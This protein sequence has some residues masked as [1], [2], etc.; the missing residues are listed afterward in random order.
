M[1]RRARPG[2]LVTRITTLRGSCHSGAQGT[3]VMAHQPIRGQ[4]GLVIGQSEARAPDKNADRSPVSERCSGC[5]AVPDPEQTHLQIIIAFS[6]YI[7]ASDLISMQTKKMM[8]RNNL[9]GS[10]FNI[11]LEKLKLESFSFNS[12]CC[13]RCLSNRCFI[14]CALVL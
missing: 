6:S 3:L 5:S 8:T 4:H 1:S 7:A 13:L 9:L 10:N 14:W 12:F 2:P 11:E